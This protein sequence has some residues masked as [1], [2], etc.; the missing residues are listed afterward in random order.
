MNASLSPETDGRLARF[1]N[2]HPWWFVLALLGILEGILVGL[3]FLGRAFIR[4]S[5]VPAQP[6][7]DVLELLLVIVAFLLISR[8]K[9]WRQTG[10]MQG[11]TWKDMP[12]LLFPIIFM[13]FIAIPTLF[14]LIFGP[15]KVALDQF[16]SLALFC[17][18]V[19]LAEE[20]LCRGLILQAFLPKGVLR[21]IILSALVF[22]LLHTSNLFAGYSLGFVI[23][24][25]LL[26]FG[27]GLT[28]AV[29]RLRTGSI[30]PVIILHGL[31]DYAPL[32]RASKFGIP[33]IDVW[34][35][36]LGS[37]FLFLLYLIYA[38]IALRPSKLAELRAHYQSK[39]VDLPPV[40]TVDMPP[41]DLPA[42]E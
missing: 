20:S 13:L 5:H 23:G 25:I 42:Q 19:G 34:Q 8:L 33:P 7:R 4:F 9:W 12:L 3:G 35:A 11:I 31:Y 36:L 37:G 41:V 18:L 10:F 39:K 26:A 32:V 17:G 2:A 22:G 6:V 28:Y 40:E 1:V 21:A 27:L 29:I 16:L 24:Q 38:A 30:W 14:P 15:N